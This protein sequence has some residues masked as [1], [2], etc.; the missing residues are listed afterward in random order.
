[1]TEIIRHLNDQ[2]RLTFEK[3]LFHERGAF[4]FKEC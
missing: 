3:E 2:F 4:W 1:M